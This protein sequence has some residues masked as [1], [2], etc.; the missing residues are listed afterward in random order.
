MVGT[1]DEALLYVDVQQFQDVVL[2]SRQDPR[3]LGSW[4]RPDAELCSCVTKLNF[5]SLD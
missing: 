5:V 3:F 2:L 4:I 1:V